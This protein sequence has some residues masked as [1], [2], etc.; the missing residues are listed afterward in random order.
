[1]PFFK[2]FKGLSSELPSS[3]KEGQVY[4]TTDTGN[5]YVD[6]SDSNRIAVNA[7][8]LSSPRKINIKG[9]VQGGQFDGSKDTDIIV[10][11]GNVEAEKVQFDDGK[12]FQEKYNSGELNGP[13]GPAGKDGTPGTNGANGKDG[14]SPTVAVSKSGTVTTIKITDAAGE[15][16]QL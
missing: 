10:T 5:L 1:M 9:A 16:P 12:T 2:I 4:L 14:I 11:L 3:K 7:E 6:V 13:I 8:K 15:K